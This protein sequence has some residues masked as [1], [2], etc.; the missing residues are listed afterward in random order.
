MYDLPRCLLF[1]ILFASL[2]SPARAE[3]AAHVLLLNSYHNGLDWTDNEISGIREVLAGSPQPIELHYEYMDTK[4]IADATHFANFREL[5]AYKYRTTRFAAILTTDNDAFNFL[6]IYRN[7]PAFS[8]VPVIFTGVNFFQPSMLDGLH[9]FTGVAETQEGGRTVAAMLQLHPATKR[10]VIILDAT[11]TGSAI[12]RDLEPML[13]PYAARVQF[14][15]WDQYSLKQLPGQL[16]ALDQT[17]LVLLMPFARDSSNTFITYADMAGLV[18]RSSPSP[19]YGT[20]DFYMGHGITGGRLTSGVAQGRAAAGLLLQVLSGKR[21]EQ[22]P[23][24][25]VTPSELQFDTRELARRHIA[26]S[27]LP[28]GSQL[29]FQPWYRT[30]QSR[31]WLGAALFLLT[32]IMLWGWWRTYRVKRKNELQLERN[33]EQLAAILNATTESVFHVDENGVILALND[34]A[35][36]RLNQNPQTMRG[37][38]VFDFFPPEVARKRR[39]SLACVF[40]SGQSIYT[41]DTRE[42]RYYSLNYYP[43]IDKDGRVSSVVVYAADITERKHAEV[44]LHESH[45]QIHLLLNSMAEGAY[46]VDTDGCCKFVNQ[47]FLRI[48]GYESEQEIIGQ[49]IH[50]LIHHTHADGSPYLAFNCKMYQAYRNNQAV[51]I[52]DEVFWSK[53][54]TAIPVEYWSQ[55]ILVDGVMQGAIAT[56]IDITER[57]QAEAQISH[58]AFYDPLTQLPNRRLLNDRL[59]Q[60]IAACQ[61]NGLYAA[62]LFLDLDNFKPLNDLHGHATG[63]LLLIEAAHRL[64]DC[65]RETD[66]VAR[67]GGD[68]FVVILGELHQDQDEATRQARLV[69]EKI[70]T[71]LSEP[72]FLKSA[73]NERSLEDCIEHRCTTSIGMSVFNHQANRDDILKWADMAMYAAKQGG[74]NHVVVYQPAQTGLLNSPG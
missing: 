2:F 52:D 10:I 16:A 27:V 6:K 59:G 49:P 47:S 28:P 33:R 68:E 53:N 17:T 71:A 19:V 70:L 66:T 51:H 14:E 15:F 26:T 38:Y 61:R 30:Y 5:L 18:S 67:F 43:I 54:G 12:H 42:Q 44:A 9:G 56:F 60:T 29:L 36:H 4:R 39:D 55:P 1:A 22:I 40:R 58:L 45:Q 72:Y 48:L 57:R 69:A 41:E 46:G 32:Q 37:Q 3:E 11:T 31:L 65:I 35:A 25:T 23:V 50:E 24:L 73:Q 8:Q 62:L 21:P 63:D 20:Y 64:G 74:R 7:D 13:T 34:I